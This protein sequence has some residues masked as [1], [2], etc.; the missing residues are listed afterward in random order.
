MLPIPKMKCPS[1]GGEFARFTSLRL[2]PF[3]P[4][5]CPTCGAGVKR[6]N[7]LVPLL[8]ALTGILAFGYVQSVVPLEPAGN[9]LLLFGILAA[10]LL[11]DEATAKLE[12]ATPPTRWSGPDD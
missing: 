11:I 7:K 5:D 3:K 4:I 12:V 10:A 8:I 1:C 2:S 9:I 6:K